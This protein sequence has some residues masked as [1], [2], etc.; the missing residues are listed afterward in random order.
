MV[1]RYSRDVGSPHRH[2]RTRLYFTSESHI[3][4]VTN[5]LRC[6]KL[7]DVSFLSQRHIVKQLPAHLAHKY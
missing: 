7:F 6:A 1:F 2:V 4:T 5:A 3:H